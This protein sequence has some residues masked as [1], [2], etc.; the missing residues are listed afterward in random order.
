M[1]FAQLILRALFSQCPPSPLAST[2]FLPPLFQGSL[3]P[4]GKDLLDAFHLRLS[5]P[6]FFI[7]CNVWLWISMFVPTCC[8]VWNWSIYEYSRISLEV[9][10]CYFILE[11]YCLFSLMVSGLSSH[12]FS[13]TQALS[14]RGSTL[15]S[16]LKSNKTLVGHSHQLC[17]IALA[18]FPGKTDCR[19]KVLWLD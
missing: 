1:S 13:V 7:L 8:W 5:I 9:I 4:G 15:W 18:Y 2:F 16:D 3:S 17:A 14:G 12:C 6:K 11:K 19:S 10:L